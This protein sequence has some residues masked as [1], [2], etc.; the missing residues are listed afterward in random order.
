MLKMWRIYKRYFGGSELVV[1]LV[2]IDVGIPFSLTLILTSPM[3]RGSR[4]DALKYCI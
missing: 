1:I 4:I 2:V 3:S